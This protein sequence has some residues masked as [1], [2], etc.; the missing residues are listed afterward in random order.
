[1]KITN[2][3]F[4]GNTLRVRDGKIGLGPA[5]P[6][7]YLRRWE[8][9]NLIFEDDAS[10]LGIVGHPHGA[11]IVIAQPLVVG[12][13]PSL[14]EIA[15]FMAAVGFAP[16][17]DS[18]FFRSDDLILVGDAHPGNFLRNDAGQVFAIDAIPSDARGEV[19]RVV[20]AQ[21]T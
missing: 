16:A 13:R 19:L 8:L 6:L 10:V 4:Y 11:R 3:G 14:E 17:Q 2:P 9:S 12:A 1:M 5:T 15:A 18:L 20:T 21:L 7:E